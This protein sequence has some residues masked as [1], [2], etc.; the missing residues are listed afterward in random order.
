MKK[1]FALVAGLSFIANVF[2]YDFYNEAD[3]SLYISFPG[4]KYNV[5]DVFGPYSQTVKSYAD[6]HGCIPEGMYPN[7]VGYPITG[8]GYLYW[9]KQFTVPSGDKKFFDLV[10]GD[11]ESGASFNIPLSDQ[12]ITSR[13]IKISKV[14]VH[15]AQNRLSSNP[16]TVS[17]NDMSQQL[18]PMT[19]ASEAIDMV[20]DFS[21]AMYY[22]YLKL[23][24]KESGMIFTGMTLYTVDQP[25]DIYEIPAGEIEMKF[26]VTD[27]DD[28]LHYVSG[29][30]FDPIKL[31]PAMIYN[32]NVG[33]WVTVNDSLASELV[34]EVVNSAGETTGLPEY[35]ADAGY[36]V[37]LEEESRYTVNVKTREGSVYSG[38]ASYTLDLYP[39]IERLHLNWS[40]IEDGNNFYHV[41]YPMAEVTDPT[42]GEVL[43]NRDLTNAM[44]T[45]YSANVV[46]DYRVYGDPY[47]GFDTE[48]GAQTQE[49]EADV[50]NESRI[51][52]APAAT[53][54]TPESPESPETPEGFTRYDH[55]IG[56]DLTKGSKIDIIMHKNGVSSPMFNI[57]Y[58]FLVDTTNVKTIDELERSHGEIVEY[59]NIDGSRAS[60]STR[61]IVIVKYADGS[62]AKILK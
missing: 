47:Y 48:T 21:P 3:C 46:I 9:E 57:G 15:G 34:Y 6:L 55:S 61:G 31:L 10:L 23:A 5:P 43:V 27:S 7:F 62:F 8:E 19:N 42:T 35:T 18:T 11:E 50:T 13:D 14:V 26:S 58:D 30:F 36:T 33:K 54:E 2:A 12:F 25:D 41:R 1:F 29:Y 4:L 39:S 60:E 56:V 17:V 24:V 37:Q 51:Y 59:Y 53:S 44:L 16:I 40:A 38:N 22:D 49:P 52:A 32:T 45:H 20:F 28:N